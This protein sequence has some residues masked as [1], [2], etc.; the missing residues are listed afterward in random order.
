[1][2][3]TADG[4]PPLKTY[5]EALHHYDA[6][7]P[8]QKNSNHAGERPWGT[9]R[10]Y[11]RSLIEKRT[12]D[13]IE[14]VIVCRYY[15]TDVILYFPDGTIK[16]S[17]AHSV[18]RNN[19]G[20]IVQYIWDSVSTGLVIKAG[21]GSFAPNPNHYFLDRIYR[22]RSQNYYM[23]NNKQYHLIK[24][25]ITIL[26]N[27]E[28][29]GA[30]DEYVYTLRKAKM[31]ELR[32]KY[33]AFTD[34]GSLLLQFNS[35]VVTTRED[36][37]AHHTQQY[38]RITNNSSDLRHRGFQVEGYEDARAIWFAD[39]NAALELTNED[40]KAAALYPLFR[41]IAVNASERVWDRGANSMG[42][43][44]VCKP[45]KFR[46]YMYELIRFEYAYMLFDK[47]LAKKD[48]PASAANKKYVELGRQVQAV[49]LKTNLQDVSVSQEATTI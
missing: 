32:K 16:L 44:L 41:A 48:K 37:E 23:D 36:M 43:R 39:L 6:I 10:R 27:G 47:E 21:L 4:I 5:T 33:K 2:V 19:D 30:T 14:N 13:G 31:T 7:R 11:V 18:K 22:T 25:G 3:W 38:S 26:P 42:W 1:M 40:E 35:E 24:A 45:E 8:Y 28:V 29:E 49:V 15:G 12:V 20:E 17:Q 9:N 34:Y 46:E